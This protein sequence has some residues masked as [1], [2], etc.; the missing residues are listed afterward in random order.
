[1]HGLLAYMHE[2]GREA[3]MNYVAQKSLGGARNGEQGARWQGAKNM[4]CEVSP[5]AVFSPGG[6]VFNTALITPCNQKE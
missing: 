3:G 2:G 4:G 5:C 6:L 1:M